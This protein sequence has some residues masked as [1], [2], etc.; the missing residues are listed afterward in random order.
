[1]NKIKVT[2]VG[3]SYSLSQQGIYAL[4]LADE[5]RKYRVPV[6]V[7]ETEA[8]AI[9]T[10][11]EQKQPGTRRPDTHDLIA[12]M[13]EKVGATVPAIDIYHWDA[14]V[15]FASIHLL[16]PHAKVQVDARASD[17][18]MIA[19][20]T[21]APLYILREVFEKTAMI[22]EGD[23]LIPKSLAE[24]D[25]HRENISNEQLERLMEEAAKREDYEQASRYRDQLNNRKKK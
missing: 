19:L 24:S 3:I 17:A 18:I 10:K 13:I 11:L 12:D 16:L 25:E 15:Y 6:I 1:M 23:E 8:R 5:K 2:L 22:I 4:M 7:G 21:G 14:G 20:H 9:I